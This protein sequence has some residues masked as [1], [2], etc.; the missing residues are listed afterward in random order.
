MAP[1]SIMR[2]IENVVDHFVQL[3]RRRDDALHIFGLLAFSG[4]AAPC[5]SMLGEAEHRVQRL[6][7]QER[8]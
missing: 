3:V 8:A 2:Q 6:A 4:P 7:D 5:A 1:D